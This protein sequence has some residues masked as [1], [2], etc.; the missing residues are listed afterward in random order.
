MRKIIA[1]ILI[2]VNVSFGFV[3][4]HAQNV[5]TNKDTIK[6]VGVVNSE[7]FCYLTNIYK[8]D[9]RYPKKSSRTVIVDKNLL[10]CFPK[11]NNKIVMNLLKNQY[12]YF[13]A[14]F[15]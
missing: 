11:I 12:A 2:I 4:V 14:L 7:N 15:F 5:N 13:S 1:F 9:I 6:I 3:K 10:N 8:E